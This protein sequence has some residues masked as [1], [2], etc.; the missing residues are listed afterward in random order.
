M[1]DFHPATDW[2]EPETEWTGTELCALHR[3]ALVSLACLSAAVV[4]IAGG[5]VWWWFT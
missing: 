1:H 4:L 5:L 3:M 2:H